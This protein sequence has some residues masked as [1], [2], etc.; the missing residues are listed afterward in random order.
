MSLMEFSFVRTRSP[1]LYIHGFGVTVMWWPGPYSRFFRFRR[2][3]LVW[4]VIDIGHL[5]IVFG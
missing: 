4:F 5:E 1:Q 2:G 3:Y